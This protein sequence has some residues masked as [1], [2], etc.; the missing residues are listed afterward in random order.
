MI[1][2]KKIDEVLSKATT[3]GV[4]NIRTDPEYTVPPD[5]RYIYICD[6]SGA[7]LVDNDNNKITDGLV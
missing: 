1:A 3:D 5:Y 7:L 6:N 4:F 2:N